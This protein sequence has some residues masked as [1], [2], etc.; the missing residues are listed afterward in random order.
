MHH[1]SKLG[2]AGSYAS[3]HLDGQSLFTL[4]QLVVI[5]KDRLKAHRV[6]RSALV[7]RALDALYEYVAPLDRADQFGEMLRFTNCYLKARPAPPAVSK[8]FTLPSLTE[9]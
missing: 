5:Y 1:R 3:C 9:D 4:D 7:R 6:T 2:P 8:P